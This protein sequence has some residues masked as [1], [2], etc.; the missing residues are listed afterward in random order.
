MDGIERRRTDWL[1]QFNG[2][3]SE[4]TAFVELDLDGRTRL[5]HASDGDVIAIKQYT[6][7][8]R[9]VIEL[10]IGIPHPNIVYAMWMDTYIKVFLEPMDTNLSQVL[11]VP[12]QLY[13]GQIATICN[14]VC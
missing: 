7:C 8:S 13:E 1:A 12:I 2:T 5:E 10:L 4:Y 9:E 6:N 3:P 14:E 11:V